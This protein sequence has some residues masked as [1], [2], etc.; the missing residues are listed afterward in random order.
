MSPCFNARTALPRIRIL[1]SAMREGY[2]YKVFQCQNGITP[3]SDA[4]CAPTKSAKRYVSMPERHYPE[5]GRPKVR[6]NASRP[7]V[8]MPERHYPEFGR[9]TLILARKLR[10]AVFCALIP[11]RMTAFLLFL[12]KTRLTNDSRS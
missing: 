11:N 3:N 7:R 5:F 6:G 10:D 1:R 9:P 12:R 8:S 2:K 4:N